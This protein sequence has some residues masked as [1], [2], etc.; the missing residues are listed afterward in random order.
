MSD[1]LEFIGAVVAS[2]ALGALSVLASGYLFAVGV[3]WAGGF[4]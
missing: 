1:P 3:Q 4:S 2:L